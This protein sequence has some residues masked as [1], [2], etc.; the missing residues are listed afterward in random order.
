MPFKANNPGCPCCE[1]EILDYSLGFDSNP[2][3][4]QSGTWSLDGNNLVADGLAMAPERD[5]PIWIQ[6]SFD[7]D[8][9]GQV[10]SVL[11][12]SNSTGSSFEVEVRITI[13]ENGVSCGEVEIFDG[14]GVA[15]SDAAALETWLYAGSGGDPREYRVT[16]CA[17]EDRV[18]VSVDQ[19]TPTAAYNSDGLELSL[20]V[21]LSLSSPSYYHGLEVDDNGGVFYFDNYL[22]AQA[23]CQDCDPCST[24]EEDS[25]NVDIFWRIAKWSKEDDGADDSCKA[26]TSYHT[27]ASTD[28]VHDVLLHNAV[29]SSWDR[30]NGYRVFVS[31]SQPS[32][33]T[34]EVCRIYLDGGSHHVIFDYDNPTLVIKLYRGVTLLKESDDITATNTGY[35][36]LYEASIK[37]DKISA[38]F[39]IAPA[40]GSPTISVSVQEDTTSTHNGSTIQVT[41][42]DDTYGTGILDVLVIRCAK[43]FTCETCTEEEFPEQ[44]QA[45]LPEITVGAVTCAS[46]T[47][48]LE[49]IGNCNWRYKTADDEITLAFSG[50]KLRL[51][52]SK[53]GGS[54]P[55]PDIT[56]D[57]AELPSP[58]VCS[59]VSGET[60]TDATSGKTGTLTAL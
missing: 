40:F 26:T 56:M 18:L 32:L 44:F 41:Q 2:F 54:T 30:E 22:F 45:V 50:N 12:F 38:G 29:L 57:T 39:S 36:W 19:G 55:S 37:E 28:Y 20:S 60:I 48:T 1:C 24:E 31:S 52:R 3:D 11:L 8:T 6:F 47:F 42:D 34:T 43:F 21:P 23:W 16:I 46:G 49:H 4:V 58:I 27:V 17:S 13:G 10:V 59:D 25:E 51:T 33:N 9:V 15:I 14:A 5:V 35:P 7:T 53:C